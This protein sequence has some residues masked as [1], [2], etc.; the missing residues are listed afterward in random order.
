VPVPGPGPGDRSPVAG[1][2][3]G[4]YVHHAEDGNMRDILG[5]VSDVMLFPSVHG[6]SESSQG[7]RG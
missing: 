5:R 1:R 2:T 3:A 7:A 4:Y 6:R